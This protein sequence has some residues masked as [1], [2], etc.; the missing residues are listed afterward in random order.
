VVSNGPKYDY[1]A[2]EYADANKENLRQ[3]F[4]KTFDVKLNGTVYNLKLALHRMKQTGG[5][6]V[7]VIIED[8]IE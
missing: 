8:V 6:W 4:T 2:E 7:V 5:E 1:L 3:P